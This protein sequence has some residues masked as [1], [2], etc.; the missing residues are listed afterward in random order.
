MLQELKRLNDCYEKLDGKIDKMTVDVVSLRIK[1]G[2]WGL[3]GGFMPVAIAL[4]IYYL[5]AKTG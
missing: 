4:A 5:K 2:I 1:A 3:M